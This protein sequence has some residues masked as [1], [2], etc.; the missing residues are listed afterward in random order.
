MTGGHDPLPLMVQPDPAHRANHVGPQIIC[1]MLGQEVL[2][3]SLIPGR[4]ALRGG[5]PVHAERDRQARSPN[6][7]AAA[8]FGRDLCRPGPEQFDA[9]ARGELTFFAIS[10][11]WCGSGLN[12][13]A[14]RTRLRDPR[15][16]RIR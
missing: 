11:A 1:I 9:A 7:E 15:E 6:R 5:V 13:D 10:P 16:G 8:S 14:S 12:G 4:G 3:A 2:E